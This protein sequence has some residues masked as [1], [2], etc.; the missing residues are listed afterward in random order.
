MLSRYP[1]LMA[2][3]LHRTSRQPGVDLCP[4]RRTTCPCRES[5]S[6]CVEPKRREARSNRTGDPARPKWNRRVSN[7]NGPARQRAQRLQEGDKG[8]DGA[9]KARIACSANDY[10]PKKGR[11]LL[12]HYASPPPTTR[13]PLRPSSNRGGLKNSSQSAPDAVDAPPQ[14]ERDASEQCG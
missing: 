14:D 12:V 6:R 9:G 13:V 11:I 10:T 1:L 5:L 8:K 7:Q 2:E 3:L 4:L